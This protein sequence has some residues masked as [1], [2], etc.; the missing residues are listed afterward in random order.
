M[1]LDAFQLPL[2]LCAANNSS[3]LFC[4]KVC[5]RLHKNILTANVKSVPSNSSVWKE[6]KDF[7]FIHDI[8]IAFL[9]A[10]CNQVVSLVHEEYIKYINKS[11]VK[12]LLFRVFMMILVTF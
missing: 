12:I 5:I 1:R 8:I 9:V 4:L 11:S 3:I 10:S 7:Y 2:W 6:G